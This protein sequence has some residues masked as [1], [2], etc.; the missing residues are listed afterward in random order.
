MAVNGFL[1]RME[2]IEGNC[3]FRIVDC[4]L[5][6]IRVV[7]QDSILPG[8][9]V[10]G[11]E[12]IERIEGNCGFWIVDCGLGRIRVV[13]QDSILPGRVVNGFIGAD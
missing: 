13:G 3:G 10:N 1:E 5:G 4:G 11:L 2:R 7:G 6:R 12:R 9:V 8:R